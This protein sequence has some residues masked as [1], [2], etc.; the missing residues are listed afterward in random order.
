MKPSQNRILAR[1]SPEHFGLLEP[2]LAAVDLPFWKQ[3]QVRGRPVEQ[4]YFI[5]RGLASVVVSQQG[6]RSIEVG[7]VGREGMTGISVVM[8][9]DRTL[10]EIFM[11]VAGAGQRIAAAKLREAMEQ[12][13]PL[14]RCFLNYA[15]AFLTQTANTAAV[16]GLNTI[17][18]RLA[19]WL[20][21]A[22]DRL[23]GDDLPLTQEFLA[24]M[25]GVRRSGVSSALDLLEKSGLVQAKRGV[26]TVNDREGLKNHSNGAYGA[27]EAEFRRLSG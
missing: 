23:D 15:H 9:L 4:V 24:M 18:E 19:R 26:I 17:E 20:L 5:E 27:A 12:S 22:H 16:N 25:L 8:G 10:H 21:M 14:H 13:A 7:L 1:L 3:L 6:R 2:H 11:Q